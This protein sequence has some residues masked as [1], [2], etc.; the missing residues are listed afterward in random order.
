MHIGDRYEHPSDDQGY[1]IQTAKIT[2]NPEKDD[3]NAEIENDVEEI[4]Q[5]AASEL[6]NAEINRNWES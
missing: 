1:V 4:M 2:E 5:L 6:Q 3:L